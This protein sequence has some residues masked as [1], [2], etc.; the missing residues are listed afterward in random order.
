MY[1]NSPRQF[2]TLD[3]HE[4]L[5]LSEDLLEV[6]VPGT[7]R[8]QLNCVDW[9]SSANSSVGTPR[10]ATLNG[11]TVR[12]EKSIPHNARWYYFEI[13]IVECQATKRSVRETRVLLYCSVP[14]L[15]MCNPLLLIGWLLSGTYST[16]G[17]ASYQFSSDIPN[18]GFQLRMFRSLLASEP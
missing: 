5:R 3:K 8:L 1:E 4:A 15:L 12:A 6:Y 18:V 17:G 16:L 9:F 14:D 7:C 10:K 2:S 11:V 13:E